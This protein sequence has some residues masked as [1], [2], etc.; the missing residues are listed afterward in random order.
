MENTKVQNFLNSLTDEQRTAVLACRTEEELNKAIGDLDIELTEEMLDGVTGGKGLLQTI[1][2]SAIMFTSAA[3]II[4]NPDVGGTVFND[5]AITAEAA[6]EE[7]I[8]SET[9][10]KTGI[11]CFGEFV[12]HGRAISPILE[13]IFSGCIVKDPDP[14]DRLSDQIADMRREINSR[15]VSL[16]ATVNRNTTVILNKIKNQTYINGFG[17][18]LDDLHTQASS[19]VTQINAFNND[20]TLTDDERAVQIAALLENN[21]DW[22]RS[23]FVFNVKKIANALSGEVLADMDGRDLYQVLYD[24]E[25]ADV[26]F[27]GEAYDNAETYVD[28]VMYEYF[29]A[30]SVMMQCFDA[31]KTVSEFTQTQIDALSAT[32][33]S[34]YNRNPMRTSVI[35]GE[36]QAISSK[37]FDSEWESSVI[38]HYAAFHY[39]KK[40]D[41]N[42]FINKGRCEIVFSKDIRRE[43]V[44]SYWEESGA[45]DRS[46]LSFFSNQ[47]GIAKGKNA[48]NPGEINSL[49]AHIAA[50]YPDMSFCDFLE[51]MGIN[52]SKYKNDTDVYFP[53]DDIISTS[54][55]DGCVMRGKVKIFDWRNAKNSS[56]YSNPDYLTIF[57]CYMSGYTAKTAL[58]TYNMLLFQKGERC[59]V[60]KTA[61]EI[62]KNYGFSLPGES[63]SEAAISYCAHVQNIGWMNTACSTDKTTPTA[64]TTGQALRMEAVKIFLNNSDG[65]SAVQYRAHVEDQGWQNWHNSGEVAGTE[66]QG[67][68]LEA[69]EIKL[70]G[71]YAN[72]YDVVYRVYCESYGWTDWV[73]NGQTAGTTGQ[74]K[75]AEAVEIKLVPKS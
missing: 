64:G 27:S 39:R 9:A 72:K 66:G 13:A 42:V 48:I 68:R 67:L 41:R 1:V 56:N 44:M 18:A 33:K 25:K 40:N 6:S 38:S 10:V 54:Y 26:M 69:L 74:G 16:E 20:N 65:S 43:T 15:L 32:E 55:N 37:V 17:S 46:M 4:A 5:T 36:M 11:A 71:E 50:N 23:G 28:R 62:E 49:Q 14:V 59:T 75:R 12:P 7:H 61:A 60:P 29:Y 24:N 58:Y 45:L 52:A 19:I 51:S 73:K 70:T 31:A 35:V 30:Y 53:I 21:A 2:A 57:K 8:F 22:T 47:Y 3:G 63:T 34:I